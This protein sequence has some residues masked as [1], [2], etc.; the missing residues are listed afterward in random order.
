[1]FT[2]HHVRASLLSKGPNLSSLY[3]NT[4]R[5]LLVVLIK[6]INIQVQIFFRGG[7]INVIFGYWCYYLYTSVE[8]CPVCKTKLTRYRSEGSS[9]NNKGYAVSCD[10]SFWMLKESEVLLQLLFHTSL[11]PL[12]PGTCLV[13]NEELSLQCI[14][15][16][17]RQYHPS[18][19]P[20]WKTPVSPSLE[21][22]RDT[23]FQT[24]WRW[25]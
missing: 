4:P 10:E 24:R 13:P 11:C 3:L 19:C 16:P 2:P 7:S 25:C 18:L 9:P 20:I 17:G 6:T 5:P 14:V 15:A 12:Y 23:I 21:K 1:M 22:W 8:K